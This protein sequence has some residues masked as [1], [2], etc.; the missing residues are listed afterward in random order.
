MI[1]QHEYTVCGVLFVANLLLYKAI[2]L[3]D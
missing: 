3:A 2:Y 1:Q